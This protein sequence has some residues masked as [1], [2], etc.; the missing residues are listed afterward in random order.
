MTSKNK[1][2]AVIYARVSDVTQT[3]GADGLRSQEACSPSATM[4]HIVCFA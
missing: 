4:R 1:P 2:Q 3:I